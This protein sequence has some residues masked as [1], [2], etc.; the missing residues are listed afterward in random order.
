MRRLR[1]AEERGIALASTIAMMTIALLLAGVLL[2]DTVS[3]RQRGVLDQRERAAL[4]AADAGLASTI[5][6][7]NQ[8][9]VNQVNFNGGLGS[10]STGVSCLL[11]QFG[12]GL[13]AEASVDLSLAIADQTIAAQTGAQ[14]GTPCSGGAP[15]RVPPAR[16]PSWEALGDRTSF[17]AYFV[18]QPQVA[19]GQGRLARPQ[20]VVV[21]RHDN[22]TADTADDRYARVRGVLNSVDPLKAVEATGDV[23]FEG[24]VTTVNGNVR[25]NGNFT[26]DAPLSLLAAF[27][28]GN[29]LTGGS[30]VNTASFT[31]T[32]QLIKPALLVPLPAPQKITEA[33]ERKPISISST[34]PECGGPAP[35]GPCPSATFYSPTTK[36]LRVDAGQT[37]TL[38]SGDYVFCAVSV[39]SGGTLRT[40]D[41]GGPVRIY[42]DAPQSARCNGTGQSGDVVVEG[43]VNP[44]VSVTPERL[45]LYVVGTDV[46]GSTIVRLGSAT[47]P[48]ST[49]FVLYAP[50]SDVDIDYVLYTGS[51]VGH[52]VTFTSRA[53][54][55]AAGVITQDLNLMNYPL[56]AG[57]GLF[58]REQYVQCPSRDVTR[59]TPPQADC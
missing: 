40:S 50:H 56:G 54:L 38:P 34:K 21:G 2:S 9:K 48:L 5:Y 52:D 30:L 42:V 29:L 55:G 32:G 39:S 36:R 44:S 3:S 26:I 57:V 31:Y 51:V 14:V 20:V 33:F 22:G 59:T 23:E 1:L 13:N 16:E 19:G 4:Q 41:T 8:L 43:R 15:G 11:N 49:A 10:L 24:L 35:S 37:L 53:P 47:L 28:G 58:E 27:A 7:L 45:Q 12:L 17:K 18:P 46:P 25:A 6:R